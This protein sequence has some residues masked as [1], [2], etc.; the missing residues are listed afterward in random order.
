MGRIKFLPYFLLS[1]C[2]VASSD[3]GLAFAH[4]S[5]GDDSADDQLDVV[6]RENGGADDEQS[7]VCVDQAGCDAEL[8][9]GACESIGNGSW[10]L[11]ATRV[12]L[13]WARCPVS[14]GVCPVPVPST[15]FL[16]SDHTCEAR[17]QQGECASDRRQML[18]QCARSCDVH[19]WKA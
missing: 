18:Q 6:V 5:W 1:H 11:G 9:S 2:Y 17:A 7:D 4:G 3:E 16:D 13:P 8:A 15:L 10:V 19:A 12:A 14:C